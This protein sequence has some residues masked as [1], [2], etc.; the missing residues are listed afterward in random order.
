MRS[1]MVILIIAVGVGV[2]FG[3][4]SGATWQALLERADSLSQA[5]ELDS[6]GVVLD[7]ALSEAMTLY[8]RALEVREETLG[9]DHADV[10][11]SLAGLGQAGASFLALGD[12]Q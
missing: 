4:E 6:A 1:C 9:P 11:R 5:G 12:W 2:G 8:E 10:G 3:K 7:M